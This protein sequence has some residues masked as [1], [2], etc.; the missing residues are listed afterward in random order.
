MIT[1]IN[2]KFKAICDKCGDELPTDFE[3]E[4]AAKKVGRRSA[5]MIT[6]IIVLSVRRK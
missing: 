3:T 5:V 4:Y 2:G 1:E 6:K